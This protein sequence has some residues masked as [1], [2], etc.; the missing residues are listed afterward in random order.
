MH[1]VDVNLLIHAVNRNAPEHANALSW[2]EGE[3]NSGREIGMPWV[4]L[5]GFIR[6]SINPKVLTQPLTLEQALDQVMEW[7]SLPNVLVPS[8]GIK[9]LTFFSAACRAV[10]ATHNLI[11]DAHLAALANENGAVMASADADFSRFPG[12]HWIN[13]LNP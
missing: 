12:L 10:N 5:L 4:A 6:L 9:H 7:L 2:L 13:P 8:P 3:I 1:I 11:T